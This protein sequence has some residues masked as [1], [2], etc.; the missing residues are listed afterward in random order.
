MD[1]L[2]CH[3]HFSV[4]SVG[5]GWGVCRFRILKISVLCRKTSFSQELDLGLLLTPLGVF[6]VAF[7]LVNFLQFTSCWK[8]DALSLDIV[9]LG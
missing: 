7:C 8:R 5:C 4:L 3:T 1:K 2:F 6:H 9:Y